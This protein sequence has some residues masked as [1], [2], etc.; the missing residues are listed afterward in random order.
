MKELIFTSTKKK[1]LNKQDRSDLWGYLEGRRILAQNNRIGAENEILV[2]LEYYQGA[3][4]EKQT[5]CGSEYVDR[6][7]YD[8]VQGI[9]AQLGDTFFDAEQVVKYS[10]RRLELQ[11]YAI[12]ATQHINREVIQRNDGIVNLRRAINA[13]LLEKAS[14][15]MPYWVEDEDTIPFVYNNLAEEDLE[16]L[17]GRDDL[18]IEEIEKVSVQSQFGSAEAFNVR[19]FRTIDTSYFSFDVVPFEDVAIDH[20]CDSWSEATYLCRRIE[21]HRGELLD[22]GIEVHPDACQETSGESVINRDRTS[23]SYSS[24]TDDDTKEALRDYPT[25]Y[26]HYIKME[27]FGE[28]SWYQILTDSIGIIGEP[29]R[30]EEHPLCMIQPL[31][32]PLTLYG[33]SIPDITKDLQELMT[34]IERGVMDNIQNI[35]HAPVFALRGAYNI[36]DLEERGPDSIIEIESLGAITEWQHAPVTNEISLLSSIA[37][38]AKNTRTGLSDAAQGLDDA[39]F[40]NDNAFATVQAVQSQA[41]QRTKNIAKNIAYGGLTEF[42][43]KSYKIIR[44]NDT[45]QYVDI[46]DGNQVQYTPSEWPK[47]MDTKVDA[48]IS[49]VD[50]AAKAQSLVQ[51]RQGI[52]DLPAVAQNQLF[53]QQQ[54]V[55]WAFKLAKALKLED[56]DIGMLLL[57]LQQGQPLPPNPMSQIELEA[58]KANV[59]VLASQAFENQARGQNYSAQAQAEIGKMTFEQQRAAAQDDLEERK[60][61]FAEDRAAQQDILELKKHQLR[62]FEVGADAALTATQKRDISVEG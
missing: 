52:S 60:Q 48:T 15:L 58:A 27:L 53:G 10:T 36:D 11:P 1:K 17:K 22:E 4:P 44:D 16:T 45:N 40:K 13:S 61:T 50:R 55:N 31:P 41:L 2:G 62:E 25:V 46:V 29:E 20:N 12:M 18:E 24:V 8:Q 33:D 7:V 54:Q 47:V 14:Y 56:D 30:V 28:Y 19:G 34:F 9:Q 57:P 49:P 23:Y 59:Q 43:R 21:K 6:T 38:T 42:M 5:D 32:A 39:I 26:E 51:W 37:Q 3:K 35:N